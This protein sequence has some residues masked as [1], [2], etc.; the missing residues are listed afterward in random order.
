MTPEA[1]LAWDR[2]NETRHEYD[3]GTVIAMAGSTRAHNL[4]CTNIVRHYGNALIDKGCEMYRETMR[5]RVA[6]AKFRY[7]DLAIVCATPH[8]L[9]ARED[10][11]LNPTVLVEVLS[12]S[13]RAVDIGP[14]WQEY[15][16]LPSVQDY[17]ICE[18]T[19]AEVRRFQRR[20]DNTWL[21]SQYLGLAATI[22]LD[23]L[24]LTLAL[25]DLY[26]RVELSDGDASS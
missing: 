11:L 18:Q 3:A 16:A 13:T 20:P 17:L 25:G 22:T 23:S 19:A 7:P 6:E 10:T 9:D 4:I 14:K 12:P 15:T 8:F 26:A 2:T 5:L 24:G 1:Y 21:L